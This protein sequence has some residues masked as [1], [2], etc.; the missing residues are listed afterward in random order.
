VIFSSC[1]FYLDPTL[2]NT[3]FPSV[4]LEIIRTGRFTLSY[5]YPASKKLHQAIP[6]EPRNGISYDFNI[7]RFHFQTNDWVLPDSST[8]KYKALTDLTEYMATGGLMI[9]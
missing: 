6:S 1:V 9:G 3:R 7:C 8:H 2:F 4:V 5:N